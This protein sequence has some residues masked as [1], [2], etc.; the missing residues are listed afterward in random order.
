M[1]AKRKME[2]NMVADLL[3]TVH[4]AEEV[5]FLQNLHTL[6]VELPPVGSL[7]ILLSFLPFV[8]SLKWCPDTWKRGLI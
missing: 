8:F 3:I 5:V 6:P 2:R 1:T 7:G 4:S